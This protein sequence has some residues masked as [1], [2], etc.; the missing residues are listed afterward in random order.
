MYTCQLRK[1]GGSTMIS[2]PPTL[3]EALHLSV[4]AEVNLSLTEN[5]GL[6]VVPKLLIPH[7]TLDEL[8]QASDYGAPLSDE[9]LEWLD[10]PIV[11]RE[12]I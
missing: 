4:G 5:G 1:V 11:G 9:E 3:L 8:L 10:A 7:Y 12:L 6:M 2:I